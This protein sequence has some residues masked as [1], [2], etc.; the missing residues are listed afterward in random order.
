MKRAYLTTPLH[1]LTPHNA[2]AVTLGDAML[3][4]IAQGWV[5]YEA[6]AYY[7]MAAATEHYVL[8]APAE[9][10]QHLTFGQYIG[11]LVAGTP[12]HPARQHLQAAAVWLVVK[13]SRFADK[14]ADWLS[15][16]TPPGEEGRVLWFDA[17]MLHTFKIQGLHTGDDRTTALRMLEMQRANLEQLP[18]WADPDGAM[19]DMTGDAPR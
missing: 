19:P 1:D 4:R 13:Q 11:Q 10:T 17:D 6:D 8:T 2:T 5:E 16:F 3:R 14:Y 12:R 18:T 9:H 7:A 15:L